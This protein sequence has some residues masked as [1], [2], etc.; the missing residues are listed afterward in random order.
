MYNVAICHHSILSVM[1][2]AVLYS[3]LVARSAGP[4]GAFAGRHI[5]P[6]TSLV[7]TTGPLVGPARPTCNYPFPIPGA[8][9]KARD[10]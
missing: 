8:R 9:T 1:L 10:R 5:S 4:A 3:L 7:T 2:L 6:L